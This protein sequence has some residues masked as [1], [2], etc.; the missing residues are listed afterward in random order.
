MA[1]GELFEA[2]LDAEGELILSFRAHLP[3]WIEPGTRLDLR[4]K[5]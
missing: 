3:A 1:D 2:R 5:G 4:E